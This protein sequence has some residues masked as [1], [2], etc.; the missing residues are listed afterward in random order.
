M[1]RSFD[2]SPRRVREARRRRLR[3][4]WWIVGCGMY[5]TAVGLGALYAMTS[6]ADADASEAIADL[7]ARIS[8]A[9]S[10][11]NRAR[12]DRAELKPALR[13][14]NVLAERPDWGLLMAALAERRGDDVLLQRCALTPSNPP[15]GQ[16]IDASSDPLAPS[17]RN[18]FRLEVHGYATTQAGASGFAL[19]LEDL[20]LFQRVAV[21]ETERVIALGRDAVAFHIVCT[22]APEESR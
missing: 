17:R 6:A 1:N 11:L 2:L 22:L 14:R 21:R 12:V 8:D 13:L 10:R 5:A 19:D 9:Q 7:D 4:R 3:I 16:E 18:G 15:L 20:G